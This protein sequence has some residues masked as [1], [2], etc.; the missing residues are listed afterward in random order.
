MAVQRDLE[1]ALLAGAV[2]SRAA[3]GTTA[4]LLNGYVFTDSALGW[5]WD[6]AKTSWAKGELPTVS[7]LQGQAL[8]V[9]EA[10]QEIAIETIVEVWR[11]IPST[12]PKTDIETLKTYHRHDMLVKGMDRA[13]K[14]LARGD[15]DG[16][17]AMLKRV[18]LD[19]TPPSGLEVKRVLDFD[20]W[21]DSDKVQGIETGL[22]TFDELTG[23]PRPQ[24]VG[25]IMG[26]TNMGKSILGTNFGYN[27]FK[28]RRRVLHIDTENGIQETRVRY[29]ARATRLP[30]RALTRRGLNY[31]DDFR[32]WAEKNDERIHQYLRILHIGVDQASMAEVEA[33]IA[34]L[35]E[36][37]WGPEMIIF[38]TPDQVVWDGNMENA[39]L[40]A[41]VQ[42]T[43]VKSLAQRYNAVMWS[44]IQAKAEAE[45][46]IA[47]NKHTAWGYDKARLAD[48]GFSINP[49]LDENGHTLSEK[50]MGSSRCLFVS[51]AR[52]SPARFIIP[53]KTDF[54]TSYITEQLAGDA[55]IDD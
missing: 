36:D 49:G 53:L 20:D 39:G 27:G 18:S 2:K 51:K 46:K 43:Q 37:G 15:L 19:T 38:D 34:E 10:E 33:K 55:D 40:I 35:C 1:L 29:V 25:V 11:A 9:P 41:K 14:G 8:T 13:A 16:A 21:N 50:D 54:P 3:M 47:T 4:K 31:S 26:V 30:A 23:G 17:S 22:R 5:L 6:K 12:T 44:I 24:D 48:I 7:S 28:R 52:K 32:R 42:H 45:G